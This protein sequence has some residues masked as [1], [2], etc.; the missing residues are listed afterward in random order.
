MTQSLKEGS[1]PM[2]SVIMPAYNQ[3]SFIVRSVKSI[4]GQSFTNWEL[5]I[6]DDGSNDD[7]ADIVQPF[8]SD[9]RIRYTKH[10][11]NKG[12][13]NA[14]NTGINMAV[15]EYITYLPSDDIYY[16]NHLSSIINTIKREPDCIAVY[17]GVAF[18]NSDS[19]YGNRKGSTFYEMDEYLQLVQVT[20]RKIAG[21]WVESNEFI[22]DDLNLM[23]WN[24][25]KEQGRFCP[26][27]E[28]TCEWV[29]HPDQ[30]SKRIISS[31]AGSINLYKY[32]YMV[33]GPVI[34]KPSIGTHIDERKIYARI[35][36]PKLTS[37]RG[38]KILLVGELSFN[39]DRI[40]A[41]EQMGHTLYGLWTY[42]P[43]T[44]GPLPFGNI[45][46]LSPYT[47]VEDIQTIQPDIIYA[48]LN[49][50]GLPIVFD[51]VSQQLD[52][53][54]VW[55]FKEGPS[56]VKEMGLWE[57][58]IYIYRNCH[59]AIFINEESRNWF[60]QYVDLHVPV[61]IMDGDLPKM[62]YFDGEKKP[63]LSGTDRE[64][65][66]V[67]CGRP[68]G[69]TPALVQQLNAHKIHLHYYGEETPMHSP[70]RIHYHESCFPRDWVAE[71]SQYDAGWL[72][73]FDSSNG[74][75]IEKATWDDL[76]YPAR[77]STMAVAGLPM[78]QKD[79]SSHLVATQKLTKKLDVGVF[80]N[81][82]EELR[83]KLYDTDHMARLRNNIWS[84]RR[85]FAFDSHAGA[86]CD[87]FKEVIAAYHLMHESVPGKSSYAASS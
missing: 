45:E 73:V 67:I 11:K 33:S 75:D 71:L 55:H 57:R 36:Y 80:F 70:E 26:T 20:H 42:T 47:W 53:P 5:I 31:F 39:A 44:I 32:H 8:L 78:I 27:M 34:F 25:L 62:E 30:R 61:F 14:L 64:I 35:D 18:S 1:D 16:K 48:M 29:S 9:D 3:S 24:K 43:G 41:L 76:N 74:G 63:L 13:G 58:L 22:T 86:L 37:N 85:M 7:T 54:V 87:F 56:F 2:I 52:I 84:S 65:H 6:V 81:S 69:I 66:T 50:P 21:Q 83:D 12:L 77:I 10:S 49:S 28:V 23:Y 19:G 17:A 4:L 15:C 82:V 46:T 38:L 72:H 68:I 40:C 51:V 59:G 79:N 60:S